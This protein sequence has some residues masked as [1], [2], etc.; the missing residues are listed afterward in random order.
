M[1]CAQ[2]PVIHNSEATS[3]QGLKTVSDT[4][5]IWQ[6]LSA[7]GLS[8]N[9]YYSDTPFTALWLGRSGAT[10]KRYSAFLDDCAQGTLPNVAFVDPAFSGEG[11]GTSKDD[12][13]FADIRDGQAFLSQIYDAVTQSPSWSKTALFI[14]YDEWGG[15]FDHVAPGEAGVIPDADM[16]AFE[17]EGITPSS[18]RGFR[19]PTL[20]ISPYARRGL[21]SHGLYDHTSILKMIEWRWNL[22]PLTARDT[23]AN[24]IAEAFDFSRPILSAPHFNVPPGPFG[25]ACSSTSLAGGSVAAAKREAHIQEWQ[26]LQALARSQ[27]FDLGSG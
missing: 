15:F 9:Y 14:T 7:A 10:S 2:T 13:P 23:A 5:T 4:P 26:T 8:G 22:Q 3:A 25:S 17:R 6:R 27:G 19:V 11:Q 24:N 21:V 20:A 1:H 16:A 18:L 12:H